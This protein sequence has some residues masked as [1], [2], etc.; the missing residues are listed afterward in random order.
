MSGLPF[1]LTGDTVGD[2]EKGGGGACG[3]RHGVEEW[4]GGGMW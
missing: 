4:R 2:V 3:E 1:A